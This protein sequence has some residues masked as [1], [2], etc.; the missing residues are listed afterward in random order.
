M[1]TSPA[2]LLITADVAAFLPHRTSISVSARDAQN[3]PAVARALGIRVAGDHRSVTVYLSETHS[4]H[5]LQCL[6]D[7][8][9]IAVAVTRPS[10]HETLQLKGKVRAMTPMTADDQVAMVQYQDL[11][12]DEI[13][14]VGYRRE[15]VQAFFG[16]SGNCVAVQFEPSLLFDQTPGPKAGRKL[17]DVQ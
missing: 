14:K 9:A 13:A 16:G 7:N 11:I 8:G 4:A 17:G 2:P 3:R 5:V 1:S 12:V 10:T 6:R 15:I